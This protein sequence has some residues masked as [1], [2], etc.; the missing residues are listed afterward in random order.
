M[1]H[2]TISIL[3]AKLE[4]KLYQI[5]YRSRYT[6]WQTLFIFPEATATKGVGV[7]TSSEQK[8]QTQAGYIHLRRWTPLKAH[9][10]NNIPL[11]LMHDSLG[12][13]DLWRTFPEA[14]CRTTKRPVI[15]YDRIGFGQSTPQTKPISED[16]IA[17]EAETTFSALL[18]ALKIEQ[19]IVFGHSVGGGMA[20][21]CAVHFKERCL[22]L[23][24]EAAQSF[25]EE[26]IRDGIRTASQMFRDDDQFARLVKYHGE[27]ALPSSGGEELVVNTM[28]FE[29]RQNIADG[30]IFF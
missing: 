2:C 30:E 12:S 28:C 17:S 14:L 21:H 26:K 19:F 13:V 23:I 27:R 6:L 20:S 8:I 9:T 29:T 11:I 5:L 15:A 3:H 7:I 18:N 4:V 1:L 16:F 24:T 22:A 25:M 10:T